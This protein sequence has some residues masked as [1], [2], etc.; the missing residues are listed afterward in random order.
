MKFGLAL[1]YFDPAI[2]PAANFEICRKLVTTSRD[3]GFDLVYKGHHFLEAKYVNFQAT[4]LIARLAADA[5]DMAMLCADLLPLNQPVR[6]AETLATLDVITNGRA[7]LLAV[8]G[9]QTSEFDAFGVPKKQRGRRVSESYEIVSRLLIGETVTFHS[10]AYHLDEVRLGGLLEPISQPRPAIWV[11]GHSGKG[12]TR[13]ATYGDAWF[14][15][16]QP[17]LDELREQ[18]REYLEARDAR[19]PRDHHRHEDHGIRL[20]LLREAFVASTTTRAIEIA[21]DPMMAVVDGY[22]RTDQLAELNDAD[23]YDRPFDEWRQGRAVIGGPDDVVRDVKTYQEALGVD[24]VI[25]KIH[26]AG[27]PFEDVLAA[28]ELVGSE[29]I[30]AFR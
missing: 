30:P 25:L 13:A 28:I 18:V 23:S 5:G 12:L 10:D 20:P 21:K 22:K 16:H 7:M 8:T 1:D 3:A 15:S 6:V 2:S 4:P 29:V 26:R 19:E 9:Y 24:C 17:T 11:T 14:I 27:I